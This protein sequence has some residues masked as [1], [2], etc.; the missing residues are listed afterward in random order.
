MAG[1]GGGLKKD[2]FQPFRPQFGLK[3]RGYQGP[4][5]DPSLVCELW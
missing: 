2:F 1:G 5:L 4:S 3:I